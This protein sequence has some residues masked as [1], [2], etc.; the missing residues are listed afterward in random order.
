MTAQTAT[1]DGDPLKIK[2][3]AAIADHAHVQQIREWIMA[4]K[5][6][7][8]RGCTGFQIEELGLAD[9]VSSTDSG[10]WRR[11]SRGHGSR[12]ICTTA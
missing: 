12:P 1:H 6:E 9:L 8:H 10:R 4:H 3:A 5:L 7:A 2:G 11:Q